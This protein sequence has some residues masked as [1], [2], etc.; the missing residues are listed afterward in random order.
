VF[1]SQYALFV[2][3]KPLVK[4]PQSHPSNT[5]WLLG[6]PGNA[7][8]SD[9]SESRTSARF[10]SNK[11]EQIGFSSLEHTVT[12]TVLIQLEGGSTIHDCKE[13]DKSSNALERLGLGSLVGLL[14]SLLIPLS[15]ACPMDLVSSWPCACPSGA[16]TAPCEAWSTGRSQP[17]RG[18][19]VVERTGPNCSWVAG[20]CR[21][22]CGVSGEWEEEPG[23]DLWVNGVSVVACM[24]ER[25]D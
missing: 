8:R 7:A 12:Y 25:K 21:L 4:P 16:W 5:R 3:V 23:C 13:S 2:I 19:V 14:A 20:R 11:F 22:S 6:C 9:R 15:F 18:V 24:A 1:P 10:C 17:V